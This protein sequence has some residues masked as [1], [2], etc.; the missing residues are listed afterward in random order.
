MNF[1]IIS[2]GTELLLGQIVNTNARTISRM[3]SELGM[4]VYYTTVVG[5]NPERLRAALAAAA[6]RA[7]GIITTG[8]LGPTGD[9]L[10]KET[11]A[12]FCGLHCVMHEESKQRLIARFASQNRTMPQNNLKQAEMPEGCI[13]LENDNGT[14]PGAVIEHGKNIFIMLPGPPSEMEPMLLHKV[15]PYLEQKTDGIIHSKTLRVFG[16]GES[17]AEER[18]KDIMKQQTNPTI[19]PYAKTGEME[20]R[21]TAKAHDLKAAKE[22]LAP[23]E[24]QVRKILGDFIYAEGEESSLQQTVVA[25]LR[26]RGLTV[27]TAESCTGGLVAKKV[28]E[29]PGASE[30]FQTG[31]ITYANLTKEKLLG[32][33]HNILEEYGAVSKQTALE[34]SR[35]ARAVSG[36]DIGIGI[37]GIAGPGGGSAEKPVGLVYISISS[38]DFHQAYRLNLA[39]SRDLIRERAALYALDMIRRYILGC[40]GADYIW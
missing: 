30:C 28:T 15:R 36:S 8:G 17:A 18:L 21:L 2:V 3:L 40:L 35:G 38:A 19:A 10:T 26:E 4:N 22:M 24:Q 31:F 1:E 16:I 39:G 6:E 12:D 7:D 20:L 14:A 32:V 27:A 23:L 9:D 5:D 25:L 11:I 29:V 37:T 34:M 33:P 13:V